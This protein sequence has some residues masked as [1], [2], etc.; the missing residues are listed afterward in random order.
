[1]SDSAADLQIALEMALQLG[2]FQAGF[3]AQTAH[4]LRSPL[5]SLMSVQ[6]LI[7]ADLCEDPAEEREF[8]AQSYEAI[9]RL[10]NMLDLVIDASKLEYGSL[11]SK[12]EFFSMMD[13]FAELQPV[14]TIKAQ[15]RNLKLHFTMPDEHLI[16]QGDRQRLYNLLL[17]LINTVIAHLE[18]GDLTVNS[19]A[20]I[21]HNCVDIQLSYRHPENFWQAQTNLLTYSEDLTLAQ[22]KAIAQKLDFS[23]SLKWDL[24]QRITAALGGQLTYDAEVNQDLKQILIQLPLQE[25]QAG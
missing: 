24:C 10:N 13:L 9:K 1:M 18:F 8:I 19:T 14:M 17:I 12:Q 21:P 4:E 11:Y 15:N 2:Q 5:S 22:L 23:A 6:Q 20:N 16:L 25:K 7:L 3:L